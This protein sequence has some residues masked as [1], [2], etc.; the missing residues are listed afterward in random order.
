M[1]TRVPLAV[2]ILLVAVASAAHAEQTLASPLLLWSGQLACYVR[3]VGT[4]PVAVSVELVGADGNAIAPAFE[5]CNAAP[6]A[7]GATCVVLASYPPTIYAA[8]CSATTP[9][10]A[11]SL[12]GTLESRYGPSNNVRI[13]EE[14]W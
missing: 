9:H 10:G 4:K 6:L 8:A 11:K 3:N 2:A 14:L 12:R 13:A 5:D 7:A 1:K